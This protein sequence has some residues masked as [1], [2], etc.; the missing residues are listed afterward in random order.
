MQLKIVYFRL[1][2]VLGWLIPY[3]FSGLYLSS[4]DTVFFFWANKLRL[5]KLYLF[6]KKFT[7][8]D[9]QELNVDYD[10]YVFAAQYCLN[11]NGHVDND[12]RITFCGSSEIFKVVVESLKLDQDYKHLKELQ[13]NEI[14]KLNHKKLKNY[15]SDIISNIS[16]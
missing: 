12:S 10:T 16:V 9:S 13:A 4:S 14:R 8:V 6:S 5:F 1:V 3:T 7:I 2:G 11:K 15:I